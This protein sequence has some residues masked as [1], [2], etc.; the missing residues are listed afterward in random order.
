MTV[1]RTMRTLWVKDMYPS[2]LIEDVMLQNNVTRQVNKKKIEIWKPQTGYE[3]FYL[4]KKS[5][6]YYSV[7]NC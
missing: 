7:K 5:S 3:V 6:L 4:K 1:R 2:A